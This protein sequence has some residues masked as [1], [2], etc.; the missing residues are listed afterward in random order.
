MGLICVADEHLWKVGCGMIGAV[1]P[2]GM[3][4]YVVATTA[5]E[6]A[7]IASKWLEETGPGED[8]NDVIEVILVCD[9]VLRTDILPGGEN[10]QTNEEG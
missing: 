8:D 1:E 2:L 7:S 5:E 9:T 6:A 10:E 3:H 4:L